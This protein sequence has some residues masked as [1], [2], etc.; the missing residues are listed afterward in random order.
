MWPKRILPPVVWR[1]VPSLGGERED[2]VHRTGLD[3]L[4]AARTELGNDYYVNVMVENGAELRWTVPNTRVAIDTDRHINVQRSG[5]PLRVALAFIYADI[6]GRRGHTSILE[7][8]AIR[9]P[10]PTWVPAV[11]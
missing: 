2:A 4:I 7:C 11:R 1:S 5:L 6:S 9:A 3:A 8:C 10:T